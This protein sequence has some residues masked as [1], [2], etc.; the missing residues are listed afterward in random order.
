MPPR[1]VA[2]PLSWGFTLETL[3]PGLRVI[4]EAGPGASAVGKGEA[5]AT[6][7][8]WRV[9][10]PDHD[11]VAIFLWEPWDPR[12]PDA[13]EDIAEIAPLTREP[14]GITW[15]LNPKGSPRPS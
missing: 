7:T 9:P 8:A 1:E 12:D 4:M 11:R 15:S 5:G 2:K 13:E 10:D 14:P 6:Y 3:S